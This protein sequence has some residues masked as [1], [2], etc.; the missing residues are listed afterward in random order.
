MMQPQTIFNAEDLKALRSAMETLR[1][2]SKRISERYEEAE[3]TGDYS[4]ADEF[5]ADDREALHE[6]FESLMD[7]FATNYPGLFKEES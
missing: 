6:E 5:G 3:R 7:H 4:D 1:Q 2:T